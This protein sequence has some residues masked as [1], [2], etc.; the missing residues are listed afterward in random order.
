MSILVLLA[1]GTLLT[2]A[3]NP[4][5]EGGI[6]R[7]VSS[8]EVQELK[9][10]I[11]DSAHSNIEGIFDYHTETGD[12]NNRLDFFRYGAQV[13][14]KWRPAT[15]L[16]LRGTGTSYQ[17]IGDY[18]NERGINFTAGL[19]TSPSESVEI[20][21]EAGGTRFSN[22]GSTVNA[23]GT[24]RFKASGGSNLYFTGSRTNVEESLLSAAGIKPVAGPFAGQ[25]VG[26]VM[27]NR[28][29]AGGL[30]KLTERLDVFGEGGGG[31][32]TGQNIESNNFRVANGGAGFNI[33]AGSSDDTVGLLRASYQV[34][35]FGFDK[36]LLGYGGASLTNR[37]GVPIPISLI[38]S[39]GFSPLAIDGTP[40]VGG[41]FSPQ[42][43][44][45]NVG[46]VEVRGRLSPNL[47]YNASGFLGAQNYTGT[48]SRQ[49]Y[50]FFGSITLRLSDRFS[51]PV[52]YLRDNFGPFVQQSL[53]I[54]LVARL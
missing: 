36:D 22:G 30:L 23:L 10:E 32:R 28:G 33:V 24:L 46:R 44:V 9:Q 34:D 39:D 31:Q 45:S 6:N 17:T 47:D 42:S 14:Y 15:M 7:P 8:Q 50:G 40:G 18:F 3:D 38:G 37:R 53:F 41:Y 25:M 48:P 2:A 1:G 13:N 11:T 21:A 52:T 49:A 5:Q 20:Q 29:V 51:V 35:Y 4:D 19:R 43:F 27:D 26:E 16:Y 54:R 12:L